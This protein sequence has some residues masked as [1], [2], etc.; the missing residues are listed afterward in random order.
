MKSLLEKIPAELI[1]LEPHQIV[2][3]HDSKNE[4][5]ETTAVEAEVCTFV[6]FACILSLFYRLI[7]QLTSLRKKVEVLLERWLQRNN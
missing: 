3:F 5:E 7:K 6:N 1:M 2:K 4:K